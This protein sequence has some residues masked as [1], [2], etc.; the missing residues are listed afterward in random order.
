MLQLRTVVADY[1][2]WFANIFPPWA[3]YHAAVSG[4]LIGL[5]KCPGVQPVGIGELLMWLCSKL[6]IHVA[7]K[8]VTQSCSTDQVCGSL[9]AGMEGAVH[10]MWTL[11]DNFGDGKEWGLLLVDARNAFNKINR[12]GMLWNIHH[13]WARGS[14][15]AFNCYRHLMPVLVSGGDDIKVILSCEGVM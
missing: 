9:K 14:C 7:G 4:C 3:A 11:W 2:M 6:V 5:D 12:K 1:T 13:L 15:F 8:D 10:V